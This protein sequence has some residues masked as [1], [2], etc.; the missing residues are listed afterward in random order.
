V[1]PTT[2]NK[3]A[4]A[5]ASLAAARTRRLNYGKLPKPGC[6]DVAYANRREELADLTL[7]EKVAIVTASATWERVMVPKLNELESERPRRGPEPSYSSHE[8]ERA[9]L[10]QRMSGEHTYGRARTLLAGDRGGRCRRALGFDRP[11][12][13]VGRNLRVVESLDGVPSEKT[14]WRHLR[15]FGLDRHAAAYKQ[16]FEELVSDHIQAFPDEMAEELKMMDF[17]GSAI[18]C[19]RSSELRRDPETGEKTVPPTLTGGGF[20]N[21]DPETSIGKIGHGFAFHGGI[22][23]TGLPIVARLT[24]IQTAEAPTVAAMLA[25]DWRGRIAP[26]LAL[27][28]DSFGVM[29]FDGNYNGAQVRTAVQGVG[30]VPNSHHVSHSNSSRANAETERY[31]KMLFGI[32]G[33]PGWHANGHREIFCEH[34][35]QATKKLFRR[36]KDGEAVCGV[37]GHCSQG[38]GHISITA[39][40]WRTARNPRHRTNP[41]RFVRV[42]PG[43]EHKADWTMGNPLTFHDPVS[44]TYGSAR[45]GHNE[46]F[47]GSLVTR[48]GLL[49]EKAWYRDRREAER[50]FFAVFC[51]MHSLAMEQRHRAALASASSGGH[52][53]PLRLVA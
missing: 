51:I 14:V 2:P 3:S 18:L 5:P 31:D 48:F 17:D 35:T 29:A 53:P 40:E 23:A 50:D 26:H 37:E 12:A 4:A 46:G 22:T 28:A 33:K 19:H 34:G 8:L 42:M 30:Y 49:K 45:F 44:A 20:R 52:P 9:L 16:L 38:C 24:P 21:W 6:A 43:D 25:E 11:R 13:R 1:R 41:R 27:T 32:E 7:G 10:F 15:R 39:G 36:K 47:H